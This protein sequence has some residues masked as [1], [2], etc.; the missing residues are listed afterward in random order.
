MGFFDK[1][2]GMIKDGVKPR[3][4][5]KIIAGGELLAEDLP[6]TSAVLIKEDGRGEVS[7]QIPFHSR[8]NYRLVD[9]EWEESVTR[10]AGKAALGA[11]AG[12]VVA[13]PLGTIAG[14]A[15]GGRKKDQS[16]AFIYLV[17][18][19]D[20]S[21][22]EIALHIECTKNEYTQIASFRG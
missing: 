11:I 18:E 4:N 12:T 3:I 1:M 21:E 16:R 10:S 8:I 9:I 6:V 2:K 14:A 17:K 20:E 19:G 15:V 22:R 13:G 5:L 7:I